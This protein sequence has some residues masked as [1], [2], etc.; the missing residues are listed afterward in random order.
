MELSETTQKA[1]GKGREQVQRAQ[2]PR[3]IEYE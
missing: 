3:D 1:T 2:A